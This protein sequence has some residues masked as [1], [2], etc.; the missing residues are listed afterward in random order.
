[1]GLTGQGV[2]GAGINLS[3]IVV[4]LRQKWLVF[5]FLFLLFFFLL[6]HSQ[7]QHPGIIGEKEEGLGKTL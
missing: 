4:A 1:M 6:L 3:R 5:L 2:D 7:E